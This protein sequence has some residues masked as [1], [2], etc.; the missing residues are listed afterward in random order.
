MTDKTNK[1]IGEILIEDGLIQP[2]Q[3]AEALEHQKLHGGLVGQ[4][5]IEK[6]FLDE[7][8]LVSALGKQARVPYIPLCRYA[9]NPEMATLLKADFC[10][11]NL[12]VAFD[13]DARKVF[14]AMADPLDK[15]TVERV[16]T[17]TGRAP[18]VYIS[19]ISEI[20]NAIFYLYHEKK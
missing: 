11:T 10:N 20:L 7:D 9:M 1:K 19:R 12:V 3:L 18:K 14:L 2:A 15:E 5:L 8:S 16:R 4:I 13:G 6:K 17:M